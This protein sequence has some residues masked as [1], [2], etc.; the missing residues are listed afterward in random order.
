[1]KSRI[2][3]WQDLLLCSNYKLP[4]IV[5]ILPIRRVKF[6]EG[7]QLLRREW[8]QLLK[9]FKELLSLLVYMGEVRRLWPI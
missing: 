6:L 4:E 7:D 1:M 9:S 3:I 8:G 2:A 5:N